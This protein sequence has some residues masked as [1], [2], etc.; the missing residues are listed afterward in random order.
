MTVERWS[1]VERLFHAAS[2]RP[3]TER[4]AFLRQACAGDEGLFVDVQSLLDE[5]ATGHSFLDNPAID[6]VARRMDVPPSMAGRRLGAFELLSR[7]GVGGMG[8]VYRARDTKL[9][10]DVAIKLLPA[11]FAH[12]RD[13]VSRFRRE[14]QLLATLNHPHIAAIYAL[15]E[16]DDTLG[17]VL[18]LV[19]GPTLGERLGTGPLSMGE[20]L[21]VARQTAAALDAAH[22][23]GIVHRDLKPAN[24]KLAPGETVKVLDFGLAKAIADP[25]FAGAPS[26]ATV[27][28]TCEGIVMGTPAYMSPEQARGLP[29]D[30]RTDIWAFGCVLFEAL[31]GRRAFSGVSVADCLAAI[32]DRDPDWSLLPA[33]APAGIARL[34]RECLEKDMQRRLQDFGDMAR[35][36]DE[37][38][39][40]ASG[41]AISRVTG[42]RTRR[43]FTSISVAMLATVLA[44]AFGG[45]WIWQV[46]L[47]PVATDV[48]LA[49]A[50]SIVPTHSSE[51]ALSPDGS[52]IAYASVTSMSNMPGMTDGT[53]LASGSPASGSMSEQIYVQPRTTGGARPL[54]GA[55]GGAPFFSPDGQWLAFWHAP[56]ATIRRVALSGGTPTK[57]CAAPSGIAGG[58]WGPD[59]TIVFAWFDLYR[60]PADGGT[61]GVLLKVDEQQGERFYRHPAFLPSGDAIVFTVGRSDTDSYDDSDIAVLSLRSGKK[62]I[63]IRGGTSPRYSPSGHLIYAHGGK[64][65]AVRFYVDRQEVIGRPFEV[66]D[67]VFTSETTGMAAYAV[68]ASGNLVYAAGSVERGARVPVWVDRSGRAA[69]LSMPVRAYLHPRISPDARNIAVEI[70]GPSHDIYTYDLARGVLEKM[71]F[72]GT[73]HWP[74]WTPDGERLTFRSWKTGTMTMWTMPANRSAASQLLT[75]IGS[76]QSP[77]SWSPDGRTLAFTQMDNMEHGSDIY[78]LTLPDRTPRPLLATKFSEGSP[79]FSPDGHWV[80]YSSNESGRAEVYVVAY[81]GPGAMTQI[82]SDGGT[83]PVWRRDGRELFYRSGDLMMVVG[84]NAGTPFDGLRPTVLWEGHYVAGAGS[85]C[86]MTGP[87]SANY[88]VSADGQRFLMIK[89]TG[90]PV[91]SK[92]LHVVS[93]WSR[94]LGEQSIAAFASPTPYLEAHRR[95]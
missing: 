12:D 14:A 27:D 60:V 18:E 65:L 59:G 6:F 2:E 36:L 1:D 63:L 34:L 79:K 51:V 3:V 29:I 22:K 53:A 86:G 8:E 73:S 33:A 4:V 11:A 74:V 49:S 93:N 71:S 77:E 44:A 87:T 69:P 46:T 75:S 15:E 37:I 40:T 21:T 80:A 57:I 13:R 48:E 42:P 32:L 89:D 92:R 68:S 7:I 58:A 20:A 41:V 39:A 45:W 43:Q 83:D 61:P 17:L 91:E 56:T 50:E 84:I 47:R 28:A 55:L 81:Q 31:T 35:R 95:P 23:K 62:R 72:D 66:V 25:V 5:L 67:G 38:A 85:S 82:S 10:R 88:D 94:T 90:A 16:A 30:Q 70:E 24:I 9:G 76:M 78:V 26:L 52:L 54:G 64:L 19:E